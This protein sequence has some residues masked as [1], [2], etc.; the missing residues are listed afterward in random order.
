MSP[1]YAHSK[2]SIKTASL[3]PAWSG[4]MKS[5]F[6]CY[7]HSMV[8]TEYCAT[9]DVKMLNKT[10]FSVMFA[11]VFIVQHTYSGYSNFASAPPAFWTLLFPAHILLISKFL[12]CILIS[13]GTIVCIYIKIYVENGCLYIFHLKLS[14]AF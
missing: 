11:G 9:T 12:I 3:E 7:A 13:V 14:H 2:A 4:R 6:L 8:S 5:V 10:V 1:C